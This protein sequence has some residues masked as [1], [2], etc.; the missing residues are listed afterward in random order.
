[1]EITIENIIKEISKPNSLW[2]SIMLKN[3][4][5]NYHLKDAL[6][7]EISYHWLTSETQSKNVVKYWKSGD[8]KF[9]F[10]RTLLNQIRSSNSTFHKNNRT[11]NNY[12][13]VIDNLNRNSGLD[14]SNEYTVCEDFIIENDNEL[15]TSKEESKK[16][17]IIDSELKN[18]KDVSWFEEQLFREYYYN[19]NMSYRKLSKKYNINHTRIFQAV[20][21]VKKQIKKQIQEKYER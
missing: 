10:I 18:I 15:K 20:S 17:D 12:S 21:V 13:F 7:S 14:D 16:L 9:Y 3:L 4:A 6:L 5:P 8:F 1:M 2:E 11:S 19:E